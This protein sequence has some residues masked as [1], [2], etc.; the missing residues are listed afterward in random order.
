MQGQ[1]DKRSRLVD[2]A[3]KLVHERGFNQTTLADI[4]QKSGVPLGNVYY[5]FKT[6]E[7]IGDALV[8]R[9]VETYQTARATWEANSD[10]KARVEALIQDT[11]DSSDSIA[12]NGCPVGSLCS[13]LDKDGG[14]LATHAAKVFEEVLKWLETQFRLMGQGAEARDHAFHLL[15]ALQGAS[16]LANTFDSTTELKREARRLQKWVRSL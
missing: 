7:A 9:L 6:K 13:E 11:I 1:K 10:P 16:L 15:S 2:A 4:A 8:Q 5:Y 12:R 14:R 3:A